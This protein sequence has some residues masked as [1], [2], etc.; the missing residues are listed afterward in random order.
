M[1][2]NVKGQ[3]QGTW[4]RVY[5]DTPKVKVGEEKLDTPYKFYRSPPLNESEALRYTARISEKEAKLIDSLLTI[6][7]IPVFMLAT[8]I[9][10][11]FAYHMNGYEVWTRQD[12]FKGYLDSNKKPLPDSIIV[13][14]TKTR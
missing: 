10:Q 4:K 5:Q 11:P 1:V 2:F 6:D 13:W 14:Q 12:I 8:Q 9:N 7:T 3:R